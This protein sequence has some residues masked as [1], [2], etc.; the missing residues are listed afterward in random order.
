MIGPLRSFGDLTRLV[1]GVQRR[2]ISSSLSRFQERPPL[3]AERI[4]EL[5]K[6]ARKAFADSKKRLADNP[7]EYVSPNLD[8]M[9]YIERIKQLTPMPESST[10]GKKDTL[11]PPHLPSE[12]DK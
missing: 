11:S 3:T 12:K 1:A 5:Q 2:L 10:Q 4:A 8:R 6:I 9:D 7:D